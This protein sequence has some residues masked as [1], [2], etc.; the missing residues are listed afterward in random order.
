VCTGKVTRLDDP[1]AIG[2]DRERKVYISLHTD[3]STDICAL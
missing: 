3:I 2:T 1:G